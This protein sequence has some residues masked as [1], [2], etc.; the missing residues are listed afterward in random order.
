MEAT[1]SRILLLAIML[2]LAGCG[3]NEVTSVVAEKVVVVVNASGELESKEVSMIAPPSISRMWQYQIKYLLP[4]NTQVKKGELLVSFDSKSV[5]DRL[6]EKQ[7]ELNRAKKE[8]D[9]KKITSK[10]DEQELILSVAQKKMDFSK[11]KRK[12]EIVDSSRSNNDRRKAEIDFTIAQSDLYLAK[13]K[14]NFHRENKVLN[15][16]LAQAKVDRINAEV[17]FLKKDIERLQVKAPIDGMVTYKP[18]WDGEKPAVGESVQF[19]QPIIALAVMDKMQLKAQVEE[20]DSGKVKVGQRVKVTLDGTQDIVFN[21]QVSS[22][23]RVFRDKSFQD[24]R[25]IFD[26]IITFDE[27]DLS[28]M[29]PGMTARVEIE[30]DVIDEALVLSSSAV[31]NAGGKSMVNLVGLLGKTQ[32]PIE[33]RKII[34]NKAIIASGLS[35]GDEV[36]L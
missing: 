17:S 33:V 19:G 11:A 35:L 22:L 6:I 34:G 2:S 23:G 15:L 8:L 21:G 1:M 25:R 20:P 5:S 29:R 32:Q 9:N 7:A 14:L 12:T 36:A 10:E 18:N 24:K 30:V 16:K 26:V 4:E 28:L 13:E 3:H 31:Q 27:K